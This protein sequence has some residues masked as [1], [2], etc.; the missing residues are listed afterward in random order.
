MS[1]NGD[2]L[3]KLISQD[4]GI[5]G[6]GRWYRSEEHSSLVIDHR[7]GLFFWNQKDIVGDP[8]IYLTKIRGYTVE[9]AIE[10]LKTQ[11]YE[12]TVVYTVYEDGSETVVYPKLVD[13]FQ[14]L[15]KIRRD[16]F[17]KRT[18]ID[19]TIDRFQ[20]GWYNGWYMI[21]FFEDGTFRNFQM[22]RDDPK[23]IKGYYGGVGPLLFNSSILKLV[24]E[25]YYVEGPVD[26]MAI[27]QVGLP[28]ISSNCGGGFKPEWYGRFTNIDR[29]WICFD[30]D[31][32]GKKEAIKLAKFFGEY[33]CR[34][35]TF[36]DFDEQGYDPVDF[37]RDKGTKDEFVSLVNNKSKYVFEL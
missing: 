37:F 18:L 17:Y 31:S 12:G 14:E 34:I 27:A 3:I 8:L 5:S 4:Y 28:A 35:Y 7:K 6:K 32:A 11:R 19:E 26:A 1:S 10:F 2:I 23:R 20:L 21:P 30:N 15:G 9:S 33:R 22:R 29:I 24:E 25:V 13:T 16:Y 36:E